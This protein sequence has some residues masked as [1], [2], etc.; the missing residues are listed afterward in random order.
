MEKYRV[1][2]EDRCLD[3]IQPGIESNANIVVFFASLSMDPDGFALLRYL[4]VIEEDCSA[5]SIASQRFCREKGGSGNVAKTASPFPDNFPTETLG[6]IFNQGK[7]VFLYHIPQT[8][9]VCRKTEEVNGND[10]FCIEL[11]FC[12]NPL[13]LYLQSIRIDI[14][15]IRIDIYKDRNPAPRRAMTSAV[16]KKGKSRGKYRIPFANLHGH[17][18]DGHG[19]GSI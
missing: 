5:I 11:S 10:G 12:N 18:R 3:S 8:E 15:S 13:D 19:I 1:T 6:T 14:K 9:I 17:Q 2:G 7:S 4:I 16:A